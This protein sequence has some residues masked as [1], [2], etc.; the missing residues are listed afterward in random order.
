MTLISETELTLFEKDL[1]SKENLSVSR[2]PVTQHVISPNSFLNRTGII[3]VSLAARSAIV[4]VQSSYIR[5]TNNPV[6]S[7]STLSSTI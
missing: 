2:T 6:H 3:S 4:N 5:D 1:K 7:R